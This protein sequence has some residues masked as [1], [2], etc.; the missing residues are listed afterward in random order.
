MKKI[1]WKTIGWLGSTA[2]SAYLLIGRVKTALGVEFDPGNKI[3]DATKLPD[4]EPPHMVIRAG[5]I[6]L[7]FLGLAGVVMV[8]YG[9]FMWMTA[10]GNEERVTKAKQILKYSALGTVIA[11]AAFAILSTLTGTLRSATGA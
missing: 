9:G 3:K 11:L 6:L 2:F 10:A 8:I 5:Q 4:Q 1:S 7:G